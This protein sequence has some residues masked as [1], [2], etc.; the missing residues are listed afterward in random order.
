MCGLNEDR[1]T[2]SAVRTGVIQ[3]IINVGQ[4]Y[5]GDRPP[6]PPGPI[7][8]GFS[9]STALDCTLKTYWRK[10]LDR[11]QWATFRDRFGYDNQAISS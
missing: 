7:H 10:H 3:A 2:A 11:G 6:T 5:S 8:Q 4:S 1:K 9:G